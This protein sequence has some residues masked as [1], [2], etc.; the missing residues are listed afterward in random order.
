M[1]RSEPAA[2]ITQY[3]TRL[4]IVKGKFEALSMAIY[5]EI[6]SDTPPPLPQYE[7]RSIPSV[8]PVLLSRAVDPSN[9]SDPTALARELLTLLPDS[10]PLPL[11]VRLMF[12]LKPSDE[13]WDLP[14]FPYLH[15]DL[16]AE[17]EEEVDLETAIL[18][19]SKPVRDDTPDESLSRFVAKVAGCIGPKVGGCDI[20][21]LFAKIVPLEQ[22]PGLSDCRAPWY[23]RLTAS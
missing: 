12:C 2:N 21:V 17:T 3:A 16:D 18:Y 20:A 19:T 11:V 22:R 4:M 6:V 23:L 13:D 1:T 14:E 8:E 15:A 7:P 10:P 5:G 9:S